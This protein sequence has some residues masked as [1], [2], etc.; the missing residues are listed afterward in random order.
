MFKNSKLPFILCG[1]IGNSFI[2]EIDKIKEDTFVILEASSFQLE[3]IK[4][5]CP[6]IG[7]LLN[8]GE[9]HLDRHFSFKN[10][11]RAKEKVFQNQTEE[12]YAILNYDDPNCRKIGSQLE[13]KTLFFSQKKKL[14]K[15]IY[16]EGNKIILN[17]ETEKLIFTTDK[18]KLTGKGN[19]ENMMTSILSGFICK[20]E[21]DIIQKTLNEFLPLPHRF[22]KVGEK[23]GVVYINDS[24]STNPHSVINAL[25]SIEKKS[26]VILI[27]GGQYKQVSFKKLIPL[28]KKQVKLLILFGTAKEIIANEIKESKIP[29]LFV[30]NLKEAV[31]LGAAK[32]ETGETVLFS[33]ACSSFDMFKNYMERGNVFK[34]EVTLLS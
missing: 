16:K 7:C 27:M 19:Y 11:L 9:D 28:I 17:L 31:Q 24:K 14:D 6:F 29:Y 12:D 33:P 32:A 18:V 25:K 1:N 2:G 23:K 15:G 8:I 21:P 3:K 22:E 5:F 4:T 13:A 34:E 10:Y 26:K 30:N 20:I